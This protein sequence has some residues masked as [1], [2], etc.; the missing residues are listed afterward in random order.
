VV[1]AAVAL[2]VLINLFGKNE[3]TQFT[4]VQPISG[5]MSVVDRGGYY[6]KGMATTYKWN[7]FEDFYFSGSTEEGGVK[8]ESVSITFNDGG[9]ARVSVYTRI[10]L[11]MEEEAR[12]LFNR[13]FS[14]NSDNIKSAIRSHLIN[15][16]KNTAPMMQSSEHQ[17][18]R[19]TEFDAHVYDQLVK[20][21]YQMQKEA[22]KTLDETD[23][24]GKEI[25][26][27]ETNIILGED[28]SPKIAKASPLDQYGIKIAQFSITGVEYDP[29]TRELFAA[30]KESSLLAEKSKA[31]RIQETQQRLMVEEKGLRE[32]AEIEAIA[33]VEKAEAVIKSE[34]EKEM[35]EIAAQQ[36]VAV[37]EQAKLEAEILKA[38]EL[39]IEVADKEIAETAAEKQLEVSK[40]LALAAEEE[41]KAIRTL[42]E[43][44][45]EKIARAG[46]ITE[47]ER[48]L[49]EIAKERDVGIAQHLSQIPVPQ[50]TFTG[51]GT[52][53][54]G[55]TDNTTHLINLKLLEGAGLFDKSPISNIPR[56]SNTV[57]RVSRKGHAV[58]PSPDAGK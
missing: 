24:T 13:Q 38:K 35:A 44:E 36:K 43:A 12:I 42:A 22:V 6:Y 30:K 2:V 7:K 56:V 10:E 49:A 54:S 14:G 25:T 9:Q 3:D 18:A 32:K 55:S 27:Y 26:V 1:I 41:A 40:L 31:E 51:A 33:N 21:L 45:E 4:V 16:L 34:K 46:A 52:E 15:C 23:T 37:E 28:G 29:K 58:T 19:K 8:D 39:A 20:G 57:P 17:S 5:D 48:V 53:G 50:V 47:R 11:P